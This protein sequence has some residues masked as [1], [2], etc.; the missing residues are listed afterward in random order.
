LYG[1]NETNT[2]LFLDVSWINRR[3]LQTV[4]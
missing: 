2:N 4:D 3:D 1:Q